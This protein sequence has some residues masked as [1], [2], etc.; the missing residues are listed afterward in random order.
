MVY[1]H[2]KM[3]CF[4]LFLMLRHTT[5]YVILQTVLKRRLATLLVVHLVIITALFTA[6]GCSFRSGK[7]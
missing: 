2:K 5:S 6:V 7:E 3:V 4:W 1:M